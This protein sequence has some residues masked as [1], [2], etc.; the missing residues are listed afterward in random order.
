MRRIPFAI[1]LCAACSTGSIDGLAPAEDTGGPKV[2]FD[3]NKKPLPEVPFP[4][5]MLTETMLY[6]AWL[7]TT[8]CSASSMSLELALPESG[9]TLRAIMLQPG[10]MPV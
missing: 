9:N 4:N 10:A 2:L 8:H 5:D 7:A 3:L 6:A 1:A